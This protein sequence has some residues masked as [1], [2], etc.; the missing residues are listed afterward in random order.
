MGDKLNMF[1]MF[2]RSLIPIDASFGELV[3]LTSVNHIELKKCGII[4][5]YVPMSS[6]ETSFD[7]F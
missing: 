3:Q 5:N 4:P 1:Q 2:L 7:I 6:I